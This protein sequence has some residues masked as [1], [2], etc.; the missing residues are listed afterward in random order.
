MSIL[1]R[2]NENSTKEATYSKPKEY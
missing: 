2:K 1:A